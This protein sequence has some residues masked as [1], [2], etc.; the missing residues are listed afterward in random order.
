MASLKFP[1]F[2]SFNKL[3]EFHPQHRLSGFP[4]RGFMM[5]IVVILGAILLV[6][7]LSLFNFIG[8]QNV[9][10]HLLAYSEIAHFLAEAGI[11]G[12]VRSVRES[13]QSSGITDAPGSPLYNLLVQPKPLDDFSLMPFLN[14]TWNQEL[15]AFSQELDKSAS[16]RVEVWL[17]GLK[18]TET[19]PSA[20]V[21][22]AAKIGWLSIES[23]A[24]Y[25][26]MKRVLSVKRRIWISNILPPVVSKFTL[27]VKDASKGQ[28]NR[29]NLIKND[30]D[31]NSTDGPR[32]F[33]CLNHA[34]PDSPTEAR[35][36]AE[37]LSEEKDPNIYLKR[38]W[39]WLGGGKVNLNLTSGTGLY[40]EFFHFYDVRNPNDFEPKTF[41]FP[42]SGLPPIFSGTLT[43][44]WDKVE[45]DPKKQGNY[46][47]EPGYVLEGFHDKAKNAEKDAM[48]EG[49][50][51]SKADQRIFGSKSSILH[52]FGEQRKGFQSRTKILGDVLAAL[53]RYST[54]RITPLDADI[55]QLFSQAS[56]RPIYL[57]PSLTEDYF[58]PARQITDFQ[59]RRLGGPILSIGIMFA[60]YAEYKKV[61]SGILQIP[62]V[63]SYNTIQDIFS[64]VEPRQFPPTQSILSE[65][66]GATFEMKRGDFL[67]YKGNVEAPKLIDVIES[68]VQIELNS[69]SDFWKSFYDSNTHSLKINGIVRINNPEKLDFCISQVRKPTS[70]NITG[71]GMIVLEQG[72]L[73]IRGGIQIV[74]PNEALTIV[75]VNGSNVF[76]ESQG[77]VHIN[78]VA[79]KAELNHAAKIDLSGSLCLGGINPDPRTV[80]GY[81][82]FREAQDPT[83][84]GYMN[85]YKIHLDEKDTF[86]H[87]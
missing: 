84:P 72:N 2:R 24:E 1:T 67:L 20:W 87:E 50:F 8:Q 21:D 82:R 68:R 15:K 79:P 53:P 46:K 39:I 3:C 55:A 6:L 17:R 11:S 80:G 42:A 81:I 59:N 65:D 4:K 29:Y 47:L 69:I 7:G 22:P 52:L 54:L 23:T 57:F 36:L 73:V 58:N 41:F 31:A 32:P 61:M 78:I 33:I 76:F 44:Y 60:N 63:S 30:H 48:Y 35:P 34:T 5:M 66:K 83:F 12:S 45:V 9:N 26:G 27:H 13:L 62:Y 74:S 14:D 77:S 86:W 43:Q 85:F 70:L 10:V 19:D 64:G 25:K 51:L 75:V 40:G 38:G 71:G 37:V 56:P 16:I 18:Q 28:E 49:R